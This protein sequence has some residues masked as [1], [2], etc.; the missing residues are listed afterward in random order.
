[1]TLPKQVVAAVFQLILLLPDRFHGLY[2]TIEELKGYLE[3]G[4]LDGLTEE[5]VSESVRRTSNYRQK[6]L[7]VNMTLT[8]RKGSNTTFWGFQESGDYRQLNRKNFSKILCLE[9]QG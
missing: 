6:G 4:G 9:S 7:D 2:W 1:M 3:Y 8:G 5:I